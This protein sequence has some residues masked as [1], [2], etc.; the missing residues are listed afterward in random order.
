MTIQSL[1]Q[2]TEF[3]AILLCLGVFAGGQAT[4]QEATSHHAAGTFEVKLTPQPADADP[5]F[6][7]MSL[8]KQFHGALEGTSKGQMLTASTSVKGSAG[9]VA[10]EKFTGTLDGRSGSFILQHSGTMTHGALQLSI[11]VVPDSGTGQFVGLTGSMGISIAEGK[12]SYAFD[13]TLP[14]AP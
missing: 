2:F 1:A 9:Y 12:H 8:D 11:I 13:Y 14:A 3:A 7:R 6:G 10:I 5:S 4:K